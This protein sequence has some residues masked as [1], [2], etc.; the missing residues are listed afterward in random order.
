VSAGATTIGN[1]GA[2]RYVADGHP[3]EPPADRHADQVSAGPS[4][5]PDAAA[6]EAGSG[7]ARLQLDALAWSELLHWFG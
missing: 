3:F 4:I 5:V 6:A 2:G 7:S 1:P